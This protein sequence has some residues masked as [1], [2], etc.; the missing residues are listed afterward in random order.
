MHYA[1]QYSADKAEAILT[2]LSEDG[3]RFLS[4]NDKTLPEFPT[5]IGDIPV[6]TIANHAFV[7]LG[8]ATLP[9]SWGNITA[10]GIDCFYGNDLTRIGD[11]GNITHIGSNAFGNN[12]IA[13]LPSSW[14]NVTM[15]DPGAFR[16]NEIFSL[17]ESWQGIQEI[18]YA[19]FLGNNLEEVPDLT[20]LKFVG[21]LAFGRNNITTLPELK[22]DWVA[23][24]IF[25]GN[26]FEP[27]TEF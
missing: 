8:I 16:A 7:N 5:H 6:T 21:S 11:W 3:Y 15:I 22:P 18:F 9:E 24:E 4:D 12:R 19:T 26:P 17:P 13:I 10:L 25:A 2:G 14:G 27:K 1:F 23:G 20:D